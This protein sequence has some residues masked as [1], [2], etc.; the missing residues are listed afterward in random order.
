[1][2][3]TLTG[4]IVDGMFVIQANRW[5]NRMYSIIYN[6]QYKQKLTKFD[7]DIEIWS[8]VDKQNTNTHTTMHIY[9]HYN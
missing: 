3:F 1:M 9:V 4:V 6:E 8:S 7:R 5:L 2:K